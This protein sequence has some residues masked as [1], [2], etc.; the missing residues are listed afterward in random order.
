MGASWPPLRRPA[1]RSIPGL[2]LALESLGH[3]SIVADQ[4]FDHG[5][6]GIVGGRWL[7]DATGDVT[8]AANGSGHLESTSGTAHTAVRKGGPA[9]VA[10]PRDFTYFFLR[11]AARCAR[12]FNPWFRPERSAADCIL[13]AAFLVMAFFAICGCHLL[14]FRWPPRRPTGPIRRTVYSCF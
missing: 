10:S 8:Q 3:V 14:R 1:L 12:A 11:A 4:R 7:P 13:R 5:V 6:A 2:L 9:P